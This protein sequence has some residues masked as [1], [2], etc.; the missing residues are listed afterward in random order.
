MYFDTCIKHKHYIRCGV[1]HSKFIGDQLILGH[2]CRRYKT[3]FGQPDKRT[4]ITKKTWND[5]K[6]IWPKNTWICPRNTC[7]QMK[8]LPTMPLF[9][10]WMLVNAK[11]SAFAHNY[12]PS[13]KINKYMSY[14]GHNI[15][16]SWLEVGAYLRLLCFNDNHV[17]HVEVTASSP[18]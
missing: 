2:K 18:F 3:R 5:L 4:D 14:L 6:W 12:C 8:A 16:T 10:T 11:N 13:F 9:D 17:A 1:N 15:I 7:G